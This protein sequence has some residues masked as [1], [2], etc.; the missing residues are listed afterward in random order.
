[1]SEQERYAS[2]ETWSGV[3]KD[4]G[5][6]VSIPMIRARLEE[7]GVVG[8][9]VRDRLGRIVVN[10]YYPEQKVRNA[11]LDLLNPLGV[12][13]F[14]NVDFIRRDLLAFAAELGEGFTPLDLTTSNIVSLGIQ[15][16]N[17]QNFLGQ[18]YLRYAAKGLVA[19]E[20]APMKQAQ[21]LKMLL[22]RAGFRL[23]PEGYFE[24]P[25]NMRRDLGAFV[26]QWKS[27]K[28]ISDLTP[29]SIRNIR[30]LAGN[31]RFYKGRDYLNQAALHSGWALDLKEAKTMHV[32]TLHRLIQVAEA[33]PMNESYFKNLE[34]ILFDLEAFAVQAGK[35]GAAAELSWRDVAEQTVVCFN[36]SKVP[37]FTYLNRAGVALG[38]G[39]RAKDVA[40]KRA[41]ILRRLK[42]IAGL[43]PPSHD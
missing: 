31:Q 13:Y 18:A 39:S 1:M 34:A 21:I 42:E 9:T 5:T 29:R 25:E 40:S 20:G 38:F 28:T 6:P 26:D 16:Q 7:V 41:L 37:G 23:F 11:C 36:R 15:A 2:I 32:E 10:G 33:M 12:R 17:G 22:E 43:S 19:K 4:E 14:S 8:M 35:A 30:I 24:D 27:G 3:F